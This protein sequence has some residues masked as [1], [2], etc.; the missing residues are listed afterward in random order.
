MSETSFDFILNGEPKRVVD[1]SPTTTVLQYLRAEGLTG[2]KEGCAEGDCGACT[3]LLVETNAR[4][5]QTF[6]AF[7]S[8]IALLPMV[9]G[10]EIVTVEGVGAG[11]LH[12]VQRAMVKNYGS[13]CGYCTPGFVVSMV[14]CK[15]RTDC[16]TRAHVG[17]QLAGNLCRCTGYRPIRDAMVEALADGAPDVLLDRLKAPAREVPSLDYAGRGDRFLR[18]TA[19]ADLLALRAAHPDAVLVA[20]ATEIGV[21]LNKKDRPFPFLISTEGVAEL[22]AI[23]RRDDAFVVG[24]AATLTA[25][26]EALDGEF[27]AVDKMLWVFASRQIRNRATLAGNLVTASPIGDMAPVLLALDAELVLASPRGERTIALADFFLAYRKTALAPDEIVRSIRIPRRRAAAGGRLLIDSYKVSKRRELDISIVAAAFAIELDAANVVRWARL[28][29]GG[30]AATPARARATEELLVGRAWTQATIDDAT[31]ALAAEFKP[32]DDVR[33]GA[34]YRRGL[35]PGLLEK[36]FAA[37]RS[38]AADLPISFDLGAP[39]VDHVGAAHTLKHE[40]AI[41][42]VTGAALYVDDEA[43]RRPM[44]ELWPVLAPHARARILRRDA[45]RA[46]E[47]PGVALVLLAEDIPGDN[48]VGAIRKDEVLLAKDEVSFHGQIVAVV[49]GESIAACKAAAKLV[50][51]DYEPLPAILGARA[52]AEADS[53]HTTPHVIR[54]GDA[55]RA[56]EESPFVVRGELDIG[57]QEHFYLESHAA[58]AEAG[59]DGDVTVVSSTQ[60]PSEVQAVV[61]HVLH[62]PRNRVVVQSPRMGGGFGGKETQG[63]TWAALTA[64]AAVKTRRPVRVQL[65]RDVDM[66]VTGKRHPF[67]ARYAAGFDADGRLRGAEVELV[68]DGGWALDLSESISDRALFHL[69]NSYYI[70]SAHFSGRVGKTNVVSNTA[71][72]GFGGP[73]GMLVIEEILASIA[74]RL[75]LLPEDVRE[76]NLYRGEGAT[77]TTHYGQHLDDNRIQRIWSELRASSEIDARR[78]DLASFNASSPRIKRGIA[79][80]PVKFGISFT[81]SFLNQ[82]GALVLVYRDGTVQVNHGGTEMGQGLYTKMLGIA[83]R[84]LGLPATM[85]RVM[86]TRTDKVPNTSATAAS[87]GSDLNGAAVQAACETIRARL[88]DVAADLFGVDASAIVF[89][90]GVVTAPGSGHVSMGPQAAPNPDVAPLR[91]STPFAA[92]VERAYMKQVSLSAAGFYKTPG[93]AYDRAKGH[94]KPFHYFAYGA[95]VAEVEIDGYTGMKR[96]RR[97]DILHDVGDSLN[98]AIDRGQVEGG[99]VQGMGW[100]TGEEL[101]WDARGR[102]LTHS[103][104]TYQ[105]PAIGDVPPDFRVQLLPEAPQANVVHGSKA[106]GE[107]PLMLAMSVREAIRDALGAFGA[108]TDATLASPAT[109]EAIFAEIEARRAR[110]AGVDDDKAAE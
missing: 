69:D 90:N 71:F 23:T 11:G 18:P 96:V 61:S 29:Y 27:P 91:Q 50:E 73:Q 85:I 63:N 98:P 46:R 24:G 102:L 74:R 7:N 22:R 12:A 2:T 42:H 57:G 38:E 97:V 37:D 1:R 70:P 10:R 45:T 81:A 58:W 19:L 13:Q 103:A 66:T 86:K 56:V 39:N 88:A 43:Q 78:R 82:A 5:E 51:V 3:T 20:G 48:D 49:V 79:M 41:G 16:A 75:D 6:R 59:D 93:L 109:H 34:A 8:C 101:K 89:A 9:A 80:T 72:R 52:A 108:A 17:D 28:A 67:F 47:A 15:A 55:R 31:R 83:M 62:L 44:L 60:H 21:D 33:A 32:I 87:S 65:D 99:F 76:R 14:E 110:A 35:V 95:A 64:L 84:E 36:F 105:I 54:R 40:S 26:E 104:S 30:V 100:L 77:N 92:L 25:L 4:G 94:G 107:P 68:S 106:V 53:F